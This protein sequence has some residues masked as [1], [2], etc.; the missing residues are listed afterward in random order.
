MI[1]SGALNG[2]ISFIVVLNLRDKKFVIYVILQ[3]FEFSKKGIYI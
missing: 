1:L 2:L 3:S